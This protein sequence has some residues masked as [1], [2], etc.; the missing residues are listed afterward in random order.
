MV[1]IDFK[2]TNDCVNNRPELI[3]EAMRQAEEYEVFTFKDFDEERLFNNY[4]NAKDSLFSYDTNEEYCDEEQKRYIFILSSFNQILFQNIQFLVNLFVNDRI[5]CKVIDIYNG[6][7]DED[8]ISMCLIIF[9]NFSYLNDI[10]EFYAYMPN[11]AT[12]MIGSINST[13]PKISKFTRMAL[14]NLLLD[15]DFYNKIEGDDLI[16]LYKE[17]VQ[18]EEESENNLNNKDVDNE[19]YISYLQFLYALIINYYNPSLL[20]NHIEY[21]ST[22]LITA[23]EYGSNLYNYEMITSFSLRIFKISLQKDKYFNNDQIKQILS[24][25]KPDLIEKLG[26]MIGEEENSDFIKCIIE[27]LMNFE[28]DITPFITDSLLRVLGKPTFDQYKSKHILLMLLY[29]IIQKKIW[30]P[31][32][33]I[34]GDQDFEINS[35]NRI[36]SDFIYSFAKNAVEG[37]YEEKRLSILNLCEIG[38]EIIGLF[39]DIFQILIDFLSTDDRSIVVPLL[40][41]MQNL[42]SNCQQFCDFILSNEVNM[43]ILHDFIFDPETS[44]IEECK[45]IIISINLMMEQLTSNPEDQ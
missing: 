8:I 27:N 14:G 4:P 2:P 12:K 34:T 38:Y 1:E 39:P 11:L 17:F 16:M 26:F 41:L 6:S 20:V 23:T 22:L 43:N 36:N 13:S 28:I 18:L 10:N 32:V 42:I 44:N 15:K 21:V 37:S 3:Q 19:I 9:C 24:L 29:E 45:N 35:Q 40:N 31:E 7:I 33:I 5:I 25:F 30:L